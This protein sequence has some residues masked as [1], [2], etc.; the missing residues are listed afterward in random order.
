M[1][2]ADLHAVEVE[3]TNVK[4]LGNLSLNLWDCGGYGMVMDHVVASSHTYMCMFVHTRYR[5]EAFMQNYF[6]NQKENIF[7]NVGVLIYVFDVESST[8][9]VLIPFAFFLYR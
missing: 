5:Q 8:A 9:Q 6:S 1:I 4:F 3:H 2:R 7:R